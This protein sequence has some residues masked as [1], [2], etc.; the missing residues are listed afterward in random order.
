MRK[1]PK[2]S[3][4]RATV[5]IILEA[6]A[7]ILEDGGLVMLNTNLIA[8]RAGV[9]IGPLYQYFPTK[10]AIVAELARRERSGLAAA[11]ATIEA[12][13]R[14]TDWPTLQDSLIA[15]AV[16][17]QLSRP[18]LARALEYAEATLEAPAA[19]EDF[20]K[21]VSAVVARLL[22]LKNKVSADEVTTAAH[23]LVAMTKGM[24]DAA[25]MRGEQDKASLATRIGRAVSGYLAQ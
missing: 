1:Q 24:T 4:S 2:Q 12:N 15:A 16:N 13:A 8:E 11:L 14:V 17:H 18:R 20:N 10:E 21:D 23:D 9:S 25:G 19:A 22:A 3:R 7:R 5:D 6:A